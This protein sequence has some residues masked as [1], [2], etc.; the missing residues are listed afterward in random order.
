MLITNHCQSRM[1][2]RGLPKNII[3]TVFECGNSKGDKLILDKKS[4]QKVIDE[5]DN[6]RKDLLKVMDKG[7]VTL[8]IDND[9]LITAYN[10][11]KYKK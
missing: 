6:F 1:S 3:N 9:L 8:V 7:G 10:V 11:S 4:T 2:Q 5:I